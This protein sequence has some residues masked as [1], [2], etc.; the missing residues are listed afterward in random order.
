MMSRSAMILAV[1]SRSILAEAAA[2]MVAAGT[3]R[4]VAEYQGDYGSGKVVR[5]TDVVALLL[6]VGVALLGRSGEAGAWDDEGGGGVGFDGGR[7]DCGV[8]LRLV[9]DSDIS[10]GKLY[11]TGCDASREGSEGEK[12]AEEMHLQG[13]SS[14]DQEIGGWESGGG[15]AVDD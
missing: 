15:W 2:S 10:R 9:G 8:T 3:K 11:C 13:G 7:E 5:R 6:D 4:S 14:E 1:R 12:G